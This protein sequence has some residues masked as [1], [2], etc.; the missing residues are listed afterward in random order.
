M[1][2]PLLFDSRG[3]FVNPRRILMYLYKPSSYNPEVI[4]EE[5]CYTNSLGYVKASI[6]SFFLRNEISECY[7]WRGSFD[8]DYNWILHRTL[9]PSFKKLIKIG[10]R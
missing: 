6:N 8:N 10:V 9:E 3:L 1:P 4:G 2:Y 7:R 5:I